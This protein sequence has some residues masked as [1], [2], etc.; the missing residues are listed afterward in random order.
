MNKTHSD[1][2]PD[3]LPLAYGQLV[4]QLFELNTPTEMA[5]HLWEIYS[6]FQ[7]YDQQAGHNPRKLEIFYTF[8][9]LVFFC[10]NVAAM[11]AA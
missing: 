1:E 3:S 10:Q 5:E 9:D 11:K 6:G 2:S 4:Q 7:S 8:R